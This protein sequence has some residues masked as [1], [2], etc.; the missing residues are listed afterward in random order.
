MLTRL[1][2]KGDSIAL[3]VERQTNAATLKNT[4]AVPQKF[5][6]RAT[7]WSSNCSTRYLVK[8]CKN[9]DSKGHMQPNVYSSI[10]NNSRSME[11]ARMSTD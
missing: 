5:K 4:V 1:Q 9:A 6:S 3:S 10:I 7:L 11:K 2:R 8:G